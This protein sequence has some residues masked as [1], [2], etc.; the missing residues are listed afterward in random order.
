MQKN[1]ITLVNIFNTITDIISKQ[2]TIHDAKIHDMGN[3]IAMMHELKNKIN[4]LNA[5]NIDVLDRHM[6]KQKMFCD[7][8]RIEYSEYQDFSNS[9]TRFY[10]GVVVDTENIQN[11][12]RAERDLQNASDMYLNARVTI[13]DFDPEQ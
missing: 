8:F 4:Q 9:Y 3:I 7:E 6:A 1:Y 11:F 12:I 10:S 2:Q 13:V 5:E